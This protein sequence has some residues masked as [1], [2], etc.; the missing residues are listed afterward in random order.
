MKS[1]FL[2]KALV[3]GERHICHRGN[4]VVM[5]L[6]LHKLQPDGHRLGRTDLPNPTIHRS[7]GDP[8][9]IKQA[10][11][12]SVGND[13]RDLTHLDDVHV[14]LSNVGQ[15]RALGVSKS[16]QIFWDQVEIWRESQ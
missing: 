3:F 11:A 9:K 1:E 8:L 6:V 13:D 2:E 10:N 5:R 14:S 12:F 15:A 7:E 16:K 4:A